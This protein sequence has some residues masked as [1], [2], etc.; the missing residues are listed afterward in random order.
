VGQIEQKGLQFDCS[1]G[2]L[3]QLFIAV[4]NGGMQG[5]KDLPN[6]SAYEL[7]IAR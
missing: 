4:V 6:L 7:N 3:R 5:A 1:K 2:L